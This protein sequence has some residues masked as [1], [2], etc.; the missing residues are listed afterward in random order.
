M[1]FMFYARMFSLN[2][3]APALVAAFARVNTIKT[4]T[5]KG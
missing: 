5:I 3:A 1:T 2:F 4:T